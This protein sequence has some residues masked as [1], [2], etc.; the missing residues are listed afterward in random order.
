MYAVL[1]IA[2]YRIYK[3][4]RNL[5]ISPGRTCQTCQVRSLHPSTGS[6][7]PS[8]GATAGERTTQTGRRLR[9]DAGTVEGRNTGLHRLP[10]SWRMQVGQFLRADEKVLGK[11]RNAKVT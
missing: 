4:F 5:V 1:V 8:H 3:V 2:C 10:Q 7:L 6:S 9:A 11:C